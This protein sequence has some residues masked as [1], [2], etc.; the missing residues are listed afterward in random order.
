MIGRSAAAISRAYYSIFYALSA[1][2]ITENFKIG[3]GF[4]DKKAL[5]ILDKVV[6]N[7]KVIL[8]NSF[9]ENK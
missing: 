4:R 2:A 8:E 7:K 1:M 6:A 5:A 3:G 9:R